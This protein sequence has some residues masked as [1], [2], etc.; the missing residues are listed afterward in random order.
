MIQLVAYFFFNI[1]GFFVFY[2]I[3]LCLT[4]PEPYDYTTIPGLKCEE[5]SLTR[6]AIVLP[7]GIPINKLSTS[8]GNLLEIQEQGSV[9]GFFQWLHGIYGP[10]AAFHWGPRYVVAVGTFELVRSI[11]EHLESIRKF[12]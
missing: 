12:N 9:N 10:L 7:V 8:V 2:G 6:S 1:L 5:L 11:R 4:K 3:W